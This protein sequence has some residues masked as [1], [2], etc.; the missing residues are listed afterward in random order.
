MGISMD[1]VIQYV[2]SLYRKECSKEF[3]DD[4]NTTIDHQR[5]VTFRNPCSGIKNKFDESQ[6][7]NCIAGKYFFF[8]NLLNVYLVYFGSFIY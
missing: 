7:M 3:I 4:M 8:T 6:N 2:S 1:Y 5:V